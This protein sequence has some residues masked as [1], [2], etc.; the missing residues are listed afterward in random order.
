MG[1]ETSPK[2]IGR[3]M[4]SFKFVIPGK[5]EYLS[6]VRLAISSVMLESGFD[7]EKTEDVKSALGEAC[8]YVYCHNN[9]G[10]SKEY[11]ISC[12]LY[13]EKIEIIIEDTGKGEYIEKTGERCLDCPKDGDLTVFY[14]KSLCD[15]F[16]LKEENGVKTMHIQKWKNQN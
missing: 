4:E 13:D 5:P 10:F 16:D 8:R 2:I 9:P 7:T 15:E 14:I 11:T 6:M 12:N 3:I 1:R